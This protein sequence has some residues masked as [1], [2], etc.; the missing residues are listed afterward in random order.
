[1]SM[2]LL[3]SGNSGAI[4]GI[5][6]PQVVSTSNTS[7]SPST[8]TATTTNTMIRCGINVLSS[9]S[10]PVSSN[11]LEKMSESIAA[12]IDSVVSAATNVTSTTTTLPSATISLPTSILSLSSSSP[13]SSLSSSAFSSLSSASPCSISSACM[14]DPTNP[15]GNLI[16]SSALE[17][18]PSSCGSISSSIN[19]LVDGDSLHYSENSL[20]QQQREPDPNAIKMFVGQIPRDWS[21]A[22]CRELF[23]EFGD[24]HSLNILKDKANGNQSKGCC[25]VTFYSRKAALDAQNALHNIKTLPGMHHPIQ[26][27]PADSENRNERKLFIGMVSKNCNESDIKLMF[28]QYGNIEECS[29]LRDSNNQS[30]GCAFVTFSSRQSC[31]NAIKT[32]NHSQTMEGC[33]SP[34]VVKF[35]DTQKDKDARKKQ[36]IMMQQLVAT[37]NVPNTNTTPPSAITT[38]MDSYLALAAAAATQQQV[39]QAQQQQQHQQLAAVS[40]AP[41]SNTIGR[42]LGQI[43]AG[44][45]SGAD[46][47]TLAAAAL[48]SNPLMLANLCPSTSNNTVTP[49]QSAHVGFPSLPDYHQ[50]HHHHSLKMSTITGMSQNSGPLSSQLASLQSS[51]HHHHNG[52]SFMATTNV[53]H[54]HHHPYRL[55][56]PMEGPDGANLFIYHLPPEFSDEDLAQTFAVFGRVLSSKIYIDKH[57]LK[58]KCFGFISYD[59]AISAQAAI[60]AMNGF[61]IATKRLKVQL[62]KNKDRPY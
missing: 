32:M 60:Q 41:W 44:L 21:E 37:V 39:H 27:K 46:Q 12:H 61:Q 59:N 26:M 62:K 13:T 25:F 31:I 6:H 5:E 9:E 42:S 35:A 49:T 43:A 57:T 19:H 29:I 40:L 28:A 30:R 55:T 22:E 17:T 8:T 14:I 58:S 45:S 38:S 33:S 3:M 54:H 20:Q 2:S 23:Q 16:T 51:G 1:M 50:H 53:S 24:I 56:K 7:S 48:A 11:S 15:L 47:L 10:D 34:L 52:T 18:S 36:Q 4:N